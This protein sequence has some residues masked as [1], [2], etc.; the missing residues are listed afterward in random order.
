MSDR[1]ASPDHPRLIRLGEAAVLVE[2]A[3][4]LVE[5]ANRAALAFRAAVEEAGWD[6]VEET[7]VTLKSAL[8]R[9]DPEILPHAGIE[10]RLRGLA[11]E[12]D[13]GAAELPPGR[14]LWRIPAAFGGEAGPQFPDVAELI[15]RSEDKLV[16]EIAGTRLRVLTIGFAP[17]QPYLGLLPER[18]DIPRQSGLSPRV[19]RGAVVTAVRQLIPFTVEAQ[20]GWRHIGTAAFEGYRPNAEEPF[21]L[22]LGDEVAFE[23]VSA[24]ELARARDRVAAGEMA[25]TREA[26]A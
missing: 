22:G 6:G 7:S 8:V 26:L 14:S 23:P 2:F 4:R 1:P 9:F 19:P 17:G 25:A 24:A 16:E 18:W 12:R 5:D 10:E 21:P 20:T 3:P 11:A 15:G 13:W